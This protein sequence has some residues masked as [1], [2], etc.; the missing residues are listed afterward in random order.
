MHWTIVDNAVLSC[1]QD[2]T[3]SVIEYITITSTGD[4][5]DFGDLTVGRFQLDATS[6]GTGERGIFAG[7]YQTLNVIDYITINSVGDA[8]DFGDLNVGIEKGTG[9]REIGTKD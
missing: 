5:T 9:T 6:N 1:I 2:N 7:G 3:H 4:A 8:T